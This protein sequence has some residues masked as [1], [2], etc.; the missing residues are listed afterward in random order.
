M[1][2]TVMQEPPGSANRE[3]MDRKLRSRYF[4]LLRSILKEQGLESV[5]KRMV[6]ALKGFLF[7][8]RFSF[9]DIEHQENFYSA[10][11]RF[12][13]RC[14]P[15]CLN[16]A[17]LYLLSTDLCFHKVLAEYIAKQGKLESRPGYYR[18]IASYDIYQMI[19]KLA[20]QPHGL[21]K[22]DFTDSEILDHDV[23]GLLGNAMLL[24]RYGLNGVADADTTNR[25][26]S[27]VYCYK[28]QAL[29]IR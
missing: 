4:Q 16:T 19:K 18:D 5:T 27:Q 13:K 29:R 26:Q 14:T 3:T 12:A 24:E 20:G 25:E 6:T 9:R 21:T 7:D 1:Y 28:N 15:S 23:L 11:S 22:E 17:I 8:D 10:H 2:E